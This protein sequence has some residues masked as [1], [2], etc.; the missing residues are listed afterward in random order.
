MLAWR[1]D[2]RARLPVVSRAVIEAACVLRVATTMR[3]VG[4]ALAMKRFVFRRPIEHLHTRDPQRRRNIS[5]Q[6][7]AEGAG[8]HP[9]AAPRFDGPVLIEAPTRQAPK[10]DQDQG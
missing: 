7:T 8:E 2:G 10:S 5:T 3:E 1:E 6:D 9:V 4:A